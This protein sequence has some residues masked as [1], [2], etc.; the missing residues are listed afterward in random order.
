MDFELVSVARLFIGTCFPWINSYNVWQMCY[1]FFVLFFFSLE[2]FILYW[3]YVTGD[4]ARPY[5]RVTDG[6]I[7]SRELI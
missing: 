4:T 5:L 3:V 7:C 1:V 2:T 6:L